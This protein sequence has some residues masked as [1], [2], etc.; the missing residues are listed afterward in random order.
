LWCACATVATDIV[1]AY[2]VFAAV[3]VAFAKPGGQTKLANL[4]R[5]DGDTNGR[6]PLRIGWIANVWHAV[7]GFTTAI[8]E[9][10]AR[11]AALTQPVWRR[12]GFAGMLRV[13]RR[14]S[15]IGVCDRQF[16]R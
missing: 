3:I 15:A 12:C 11:F 6:S 7:L 8:G 9:E 1:P 5:T 2:Q 10:R 13:R 16:Q 4:S 14:F